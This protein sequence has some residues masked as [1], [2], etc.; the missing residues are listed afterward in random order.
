M[1][2]LTKAN[3]FYTRTHISTWRDK[4]MA[5]GSDSK[6]GEGRTETKHVLLNTNMNFAIPNPT[7]HQCPL[8]DVE[9][10]CQAVMCSC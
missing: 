6:K 3:C 2:Y 5:G 1:L 4:L 10:I 7:K 8:P 9:K